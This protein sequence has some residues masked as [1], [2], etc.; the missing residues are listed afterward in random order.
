MTDIASAL[1]PSQRWWAPSSEDRWAILA[2]IMA[3]TALPPFAGLGWLMPLALAILF[4]VLIGA[5]APTRT[6]WLFGLAHQTSLLYWL[7]MLIP[8]ASVPAGWLKPA[9]A[10]GAILYTSLFYLAFGFVL[11]RVKT[12]LGP[13]PALALAPVLWVLMEFGRGAGELGFPWC[14]SGAAWIDTPLMVLAAG[15]GEIGLGAATVFSAAALAGLAKAIPPLRRRRIWPELGWGLSLVVVAGLLW[16]GMALGTVWPRAG[17]RVA[18]SAAG[19]VAERQLFNGVV[20][21]TASAEAGTARIRKTPVRVAAVQANVSL[22]D[23][24]KQARIDSTIVPYTT[25]TDQAAAAGAEFVVWAETAVPAYLM[26]DRSLF[27]WVRDLVARNSIFLYSGFP[28]ARLLTDG[29]RVKYNSSGLFG[30]DGLPL[31][32]YPKHHLLPIGE[33]MPFQNYLPFLAKIDVGQAEWFPGE[34]PS[35]IS[36]PSPRGEYRF[37]GLICFESIFSNLARNAVQQG[38]NILVNI[39]NDGWFGKTAGPRQHAALARLR[40]VECGVPLVRCANN[41]ISYILDERGRELASAGL[42]ERTVVMA[43]V[44]PGRGETLFVRFGAWP[45]FGLLAAWTLLVLALTGFRR[46]S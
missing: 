5:A 43:D 1:A 42:G 44:L 11:S 37:A 23:K 27:N 9:Q 13:M 39:T 12:S 17:E 8:A 6:A 26:Y 34:P 18:E 14:L 41:G 22:D 40:A 25:L 7:F 36:V 21:D 4:A 45:I 19:A 15:G 46:R 33:A 35:P 38:A 2:G 32:F 30:P 28:D 29:R 16:T 24:W 20:Q 10:V 3:T 31:A